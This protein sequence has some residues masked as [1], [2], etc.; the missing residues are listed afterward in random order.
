VGGWVGGRESRVKDC[1]QQS[2]RIG[3]W[4]VPRSLKIF[5]LLKRPFIFLLKCSAFKLHF[6]KSYHP[7]ISA[8]SKFLSTSVENLRSSSFVIF[9]DLLSSLSV[10]DLI[11][12]LLSGQLRNFSRNKIVSMFWLT[13]T[14][15]FLNK[16]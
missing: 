2:K 7:T 12:R 10:T 11:S 8:M 9:D 4:K 15:D 3:F 13:C 14:K 16:N 6:F 1:L 5:Q